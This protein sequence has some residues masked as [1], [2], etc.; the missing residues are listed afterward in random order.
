MTNLISIIIPIYNAEKYLPK[1]L[2]S[3]IN[4]TYKNTEIILV[5]DGSTDSSGLICDEYA[6]KDIRIKVLHKGNG[7]VSSARNTALK[8]AKGDYIGFVDSD[9]W[10]EPD[11]FQKLHELCV[12]YNSEISMCGYYSQSSDKVN[13]SLIPLPQEGVLTREKAYE[14]VLIPGKFEGFLWNKLFDT[15]LLK[16]TNILFDENIHFCE[17]QLFVC[18]VLKYCKNISYTTNHYYH[19]IK[20]SSSATET[21]NEKYI[22]RIGA[23]E[24]IVNE[25]KGTEIEDLAKAAAAN[26]SCIMLMDVYDTFYCTN[27]VLEKLKYI[28]RK[29]RREFWRYPFSLKFKIRFIGLDISIPLFIKLYRRLK[30]IKSSLIGEN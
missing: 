25:L 4:Q 13:K 8:I 27:D 19:Y 14:Q 7:G 2:D 6:L 28:K 16:E 17:D 9:D 5:N 24:S 1:C 3:V 21:V 30:K 23:I 12:K 11:M 29:Y 15:R 20:N 26:A 10:I 22:T 18:K